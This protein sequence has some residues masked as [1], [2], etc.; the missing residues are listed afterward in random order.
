[1]RL[2][3][4]CECVTVQVDPNDRTGELYVGL[5]HVR[6]CRFERTGSGIADDVQSSKYTF[7]PGDILYGKLRPYLDKAVVVKESGI[8]TTE[9]LVLRPKPHVDPRFLACV[10]HSPDFVSHAI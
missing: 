10:V 9:L 8:C 1:M 5:E 4:L 6:S 2:S 3:D 7:K